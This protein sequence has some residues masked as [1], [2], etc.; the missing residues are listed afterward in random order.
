MVGYC[1]M[2]SNWLIYSGKKGSKY[3]HTSAKDIE[4]NVGRDVTSY[5]RQRLTELRDWSFDFFRSNALR[6]ITWSSDLRE[7]AD[8]NAASKD[9]YTCTKVDL[10]LRTSK[11]LKKKKA[12]E[13]TDHHGK[14]Y[15][16]FLQAAPVL[17]TG[18]VIKLRCVNVIFTD[19][20]RIISLTDNSSCLIVPDYF[21]DSQLFNRSANVTPT[22]SNYSKGRKTPGRSG[23]NTPLSSKRAATATY[24]FLSDYNFEDHVITKTAK[25]SNKKK[26]SKIQSQQGKKLALK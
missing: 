12:V 24:P 22:K 3:V 7:P 21:F 13:F 16:L 26:R 14:K 5:E 2:Y 10:V 20:G 25:G 9:R 6:S 17:A 23:K 18:D 8:E 15:A 1:N 19:D 11:V 4:K